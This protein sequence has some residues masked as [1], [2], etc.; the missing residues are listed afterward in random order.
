VVVKIKTTDC[1]HA[2]H[3]SVVETERQA[4]GDMP[5]TADLPYAGKRSN[6]IGLNRKVIQPDPIVL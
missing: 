2:H 5:L 4:L 3:K 1:S 6:F